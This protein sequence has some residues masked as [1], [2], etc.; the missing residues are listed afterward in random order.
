M[1]KQQKNQEKNNKANQVESGGLPELRGRLATLTN[2]FFREQ[3]N[4]LVNGIAIGFRP[5]GIR[6]TIVTLLDPSA[7]QCEEDT[8]RKEV[9]PDGVILRASR[10]FPLQPPSLPRAG[11]SV[12]T[13]SPLRYNIPPVSVGTFG[14]RVVVAG[15]REYILSSNHVLAHNGRAPKGTPIVLPGTLDDATGGSTVATRSHFVVLQPPDWPL[16]GAP[17]N[18]VDC[19]LAEVPQVVKIGP[20]NPIDVFP[21]IALNLASLTTLSQ[22][23]VNK[24]GRTTGKTQSRISIFDLA[25]YIDFSFGT[26]FF[27]DLM[28]TYDDHHD[29]FAAPGDSGSLAVGDPSA[30]PSIRNKGIGLITARSNVFDNTGR[31]V[32]YI[33]AICS[34]DLVAELLAEEINKASNNTTSFKGNDLKFHI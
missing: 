29:I 16:N 11:N 18:R 12:G 33:V 2:I 10:F 3:R 34:L 13:Y 20:G 9:G 25:T 4:L 23:K 30:P 24:T 19:A 7:S 8:I 21:S 31:L 32:A 28:A 6:P 1:A 14:A 27:A 15:N 17:L 26:H 5:E 22:A